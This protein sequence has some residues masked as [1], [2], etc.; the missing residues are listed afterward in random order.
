M[1]LS[2]EM[3]DHLRP[4]WAEP[5]RVALVRIPAAERYAVSHSTFRE[6]VRY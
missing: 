1:W 3:A 4:C 2:L 5:G 6:S